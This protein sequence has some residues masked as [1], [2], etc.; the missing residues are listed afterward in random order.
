MD[1]HDQEIKEYVA[2]FHNHYGA[3]L[4]KKKTG[5]KCYLKPV[6]RSLSSSCGTAAFFSLP[7]SLDMVNEYLEAVYAFDG[8]TYRRIYGEEQ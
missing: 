6:P 8:V 2:T 7:F 3:L 1:N 5:E 4:F